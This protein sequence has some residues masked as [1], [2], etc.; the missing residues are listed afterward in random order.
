[1]TRLRR[2]TGI[3]D[4]NRM[5]LGGHSAGGA[6]G[7]FAINGSCFPP[8]CTPPPFFFI[9][10]EA[11]QAVAFYGTNT[12]GAGG[13][14]NDPRCIDFGFPP[15]PDGEIFGINNE[16]I[17]V[18]LVQGTND[19][20]GTPEEADATIAVLEGPSEL[21]SIGGANHYGITDVNNNV[22]PNDPKNKIPGAIPDFSPQVIPQAVSIKQIAQATGEFLLEALTE[23]E[24]I[25]GE[26]P[27]SAKKKLDVDDEVTV[28][29]RRVAKGE[30]GADSVV[31]ID[32]TRDTVSQV[33]PDLVPSVFPE[34]DSD[35]K[36]KV[37]NDRSFVS[38]TAVYFKEI[39]IK[40]GITA[41]FSGGGPFH[42]DKLK[43]KKGAVL[44]LGAGTYFVN[45]YEEV[46]EDS[47]LTLSSTPVELHIGDKFKVE[48]KRLVLNAG[49]S[50]D[51]LR[52]YL[53]ED[54]E[55]KAKEMEFTGLLYGPD[56][57]KIEVEKATVTGAIITS[58]ETKLK[59]KA[60][61]TYTET[62]Q[63]LVGLT[64]SIP[65]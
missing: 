26:F 32:A 9:L 12:C 6:A 21:I 11:V 61:I 10:P 64:V 46:E 41:S 16:D 38:D 15:N 14:R 59:K 19:G 60:D 43:V 3:V 28:N 34:N 53:H 62:D 20:I 47:Q 25:P 1:M 7:L 39:E 51:G 57:K 40:E 17:P 49:G 4:T 33:L 56:S 44:N 42:I 48:K 2:C 5:D 22:D 13:E 31:E 63:A 30:T 24:L 55:F 27:V 45:K 54:A 52:V 37:E 65:E 23:G 29:G 8:F 35:L 18:A 36:I 58:G 50:V